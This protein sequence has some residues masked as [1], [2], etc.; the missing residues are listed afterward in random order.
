MENSYL[1]ENG[2]Q[3]SALARERLPFHMLMHTNHYWKIICECAAGPVLV[4]AGGAQNSLFA[5]S[6]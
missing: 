4:A 2:L 3:P 5:G 6:Y 1:L